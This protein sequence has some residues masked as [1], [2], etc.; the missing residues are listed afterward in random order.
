MTGLRVIV[1]VALMLMS[2]CRSDQIM[3]D[4]RIYTYPL[5]E[6]DLRCAMRV[7]PRQV[8]IW[9]AATIDISGTH[10]VYCKNPFEK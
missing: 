2:A 10:Q 1:F 6:E 4:G 3:S 9:F 7:G 5:A 8:Q